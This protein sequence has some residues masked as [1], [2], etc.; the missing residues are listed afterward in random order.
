[1]D[2]P[3]R[4]ISVE[5]ARRRQT[6]GH[7]VGYL[8][9][10]WKH[11]RLV[12]TLSRT[13]LKRTVAKSK[14]YYLWWMF[15][16]L[17]DTACYAFLFLMFRPR[18][19]TGEIDAPILIFLLAGIIP[20]RWTSSCCAAA[21]ATWKRY[22]NIIQQVRFPYLVLPGATFRTEGWLYLC[23]LGVLLC[24][25]L[26]YGL[27]PT[28]AW[29]TLPLWLALHGLVTLALMLPI[30]V[31]S[32]FSSDFTRVVPYGLRLMFFATPIL[33]TG[34]QLPV[35]ARPVANLNP[36]AHV[37]NGYRAILLDG[38]APDPVSATVLLAVSLVGLAAGAFWFVRSE[39]FIARSI[40]RTTY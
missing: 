8:A 29:L 39:P 11:L 18:T 24:A 21:A 33:Y 3:L 10:L 28:A 23:A 12:E 17:L 13:E 40:T 6:F 32:A 4:I 15:D 2:A 7:F 31:L 36:L 9:W 26:A 30:A 5:E 22:A 20:F 16:P 38:V 27:W 14:L 34:D 19:G 25:T 37:V 35:W 1:M